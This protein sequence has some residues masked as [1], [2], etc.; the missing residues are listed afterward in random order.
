MNEETS[1][2][3]YDSW[4]EVW[5]KMKALGWTWK[6]GNGII[7][8]Y[9]MKPNKTLEDVFGEDYLGDLDD[10]KKYAM[11]TYGWID[12]KEPLNEAAND[13]SQRKSEGG[14]IEY[15]R[16]IDKESAEVIS[17]KVYGQE[18][19]DSER[20]DAESIK[21]EP[22]NFT[23]LHNLINVKNKIKYRMMTKIIKFI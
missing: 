15:Q 11:D 8:S 9:Y 1:M 21:R 22:D 5:I 14:V 20:N 10:V 7:N 18:S 3:K 17:S 6:K 19:V 23:D 2:G 12:G 4:G 16:K 13:D